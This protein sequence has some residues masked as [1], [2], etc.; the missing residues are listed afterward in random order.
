MCRSPWSPRRGS[1][2]VAGDEARAL[3]CLFGPV[4]SGAVKS[5]AAGKGAW[6]E[7]RAKRGGMSAAAPLFRIGMSAAIAPLRNRAGCNVK[8]AWQ[9]ER[10]RH[11]DARFPLASG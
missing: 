5:Q 4:R 8:L 6:S 7:R 11:R 1:V 10:A 3:L 9:W 2:S